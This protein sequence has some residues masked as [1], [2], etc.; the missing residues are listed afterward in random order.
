MSENTT[1]ALGSAQVTP[2][3]AGDM[4]VRLADEYA[5]PEEVWRQGYADLFDQPSILPSLSVYVDQSGDNRS[6]QLSTTAGGDLSMAT[7]TENAM[8]Q[9]FFAAPA[10]IRLRIT[11]GGTNP[12]CGC[13]LKLSATGRTFD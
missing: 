4:R 9:T 8:A 10:S 2:L 12:G 6:W 3:N 11:L 1:F 5:V 7:V 13:R